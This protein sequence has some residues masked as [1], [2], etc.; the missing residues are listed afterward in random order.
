M[1]TDTSLVWVHETYIQ[2]CK[3]RP[4]PLYFTMIWDIDL[5][6]GMR[7]YNHTLQINFEIHS[8]WM[9]IGQLTAVWALKFGQIF[10]CHHFIWNICE[11]PLLKYSRR[12]HSC[13]SDTSSFIWIYRKSCYASRLKELWQFFVI[14]GISK[15]YLQAARKKVYP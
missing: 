3:I 15:I 13:R 12:G 10:S 6:V 7:V 4:V 1:E 2:V 11:S 8:G 14:D 5:I 9:I